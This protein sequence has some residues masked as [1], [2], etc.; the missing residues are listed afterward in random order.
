MP[1]RILLS[2]KSISALVGIILGVFGAFQSFAVLPYRVQ[3]LEKREE[4]TDKDHDLLVKISADME[5]VK[6]K[7]D[8]KK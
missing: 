6:L 5:F 8:N 1:Q 4:K 3:A 2:I 7:L